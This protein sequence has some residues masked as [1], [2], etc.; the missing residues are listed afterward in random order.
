MLASLDD[1]VK[2]DNNWNDQLN[3]PNE[4]IQTIGLKKK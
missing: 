4:W 2:G 1:M 3:N